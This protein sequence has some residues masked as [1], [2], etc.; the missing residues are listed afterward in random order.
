MAH[1]TFTERDFLEA[2]G[3]DVSRETL[4]KLAIYEALL[5]K[6][7]KTINL[8]GDS[9]LNNIWQ[10][11]FLDSAQLLNFFPK[12]AIR[13]VDFGSGGGFP[14][15]VYALLLAD[16]KP[17]KAYEIHAIESDSRKTAFM[18]EVVRSCQLD[19][20]VHTSRIEQIAAIRADV[21]TA[22]ALAPLD[23]LLTYMRP[24]TT[25]D[26]TCLF[27]KGQTA[28]EEIAKLG[29]KRQMDITLYPSIS[30][31]SGHIVEIKNIREF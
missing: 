16:K 29:R 21:I 7:Q 22:R 11:H 27:L 23:T 30:D 26:T 28:E 25:N 9:T 31:P 13:F 17:Q 3:K 24:F 15:L 5:R 19:V 14:V 10:R 2:F 18:R 4:D 20:R 6:W 12:K 1:E 8:V